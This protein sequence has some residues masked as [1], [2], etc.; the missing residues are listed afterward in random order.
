MA[1][2]VYV[3]AAESKRG[4]VTVKP[5]KFKDDAAALTAD[6]V[7]AEVEI[8]TTSSTTVGEELCYSTPKRPWTVDLMS[9]Y[10]LRGNSFNIYF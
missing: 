10:L 8:N 9:Y 5:V 4:L 2:Y 1:I 7:T 3:Y 6:T